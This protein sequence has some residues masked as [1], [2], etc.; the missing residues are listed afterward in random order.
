MILRRCWEDDLVVLTVLVVAAGGVVFDG[1]DFVC[2]VVVVV[3]VLDGLVV[4]VVTTFLFA[5]F[6]GIVDWKGVMSLW[7]VVVVGGLWRLNGDG[8]GWLIDW[9]EVDWLM[10]SGLMEGNR[11]DSWNSWIVRTNW[12]DGTWRMREGGGG[13]R[14]GQIIIF[15][16]ISLVA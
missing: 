12:W 13:G 3:A 8:G 10:L 9:W 2:W 11:K 7:L 4:G 15:V 16:D 5:F 14:R 1:L 6:G